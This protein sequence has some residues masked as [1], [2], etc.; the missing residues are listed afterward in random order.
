MI[1]AIHTLIGDIVGDVV[2]YV[3]ADD[4]IFAEKSAENALKS[5]QHK[6]D[7][8]NLCIFQVEERIDP[9][10]VHEVETRG[11]YIEDHFR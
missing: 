7:M 11:Y 5:T 6:Y 4:Y 1:Y 8:E 2:G 10:I 3:L 9:K